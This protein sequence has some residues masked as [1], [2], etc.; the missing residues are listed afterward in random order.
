MVNS[1]A[2]A[3]P[4][5]PTAER[6]PNRRVIAWIGRIIHSLDRMAAPEIV[7][8]DSARP[9]ALVAGPPRRLRVQAP[10][11]LRHL[12]RLA[13]LRIA[14]ERPVVAV[15]PPATEHLSVALH[16]IGAVG[17]SLLAWHQLVL[18]IV[19]IA[20]AIN[21]EVF[22]ECAAPGAGQALPARK[23]DRQIDELALRLRRSRSE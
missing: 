17:V 12:R 7:R 23:V 9:G 20:I 19:N 8:I 11:R 3:A 22:H 14:E 6:S 5:A 10:A 2:C 21:P 15:G 13:P 18:R 4:A 16:R 1:C